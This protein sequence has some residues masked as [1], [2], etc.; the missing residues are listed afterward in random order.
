MIALAVGWG[1]LA[2]ESGRPSVAS[3]P[4]VPAG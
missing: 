4:A 3:P 2:W 1:W